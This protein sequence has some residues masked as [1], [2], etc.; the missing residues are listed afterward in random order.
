MFGSGGTEGVAGA[1]P[2]F[3]GTSWTSSVRLSG[4]QPSGLPTS[5]LIVTPLTLRILPVAVSPTQS[6]DTIGGGVQESEVFTVVAPVEA[7]DLR[8]WWHVDLDLGTVGDALERQG[9]GVLKAE[10]RVC[11]R[12][13]A[14]AGEPQHRLCEVRERRIAQAGRQHHVVARR[15]ERNGLA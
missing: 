9:D 2:R 8:A 15:A 3:A 14:T 13:D 5:E 6:F 10:R 12:I 4:I 11:R 1:A 7:A